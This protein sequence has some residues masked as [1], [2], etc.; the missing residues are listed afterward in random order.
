MAQDIT[1][2]KADRAEPEEHP[3]EVH[4]EVHPFVSLLV[5]RMESHPEEFFFY[6]PTKS[7]L[8]TNTNTNKV[9]SQVNLTYQRTI[10]L[11][12]R[13]EKRLYNVALRKVRMMEAERRLM[14]VLLADK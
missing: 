10:A 7:V 9:L 1:P 2:T 13:K 5:A 11:W 3:S 8:S 6:D 12:N 4:L 14:A